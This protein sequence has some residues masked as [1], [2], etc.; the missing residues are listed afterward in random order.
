MW[1]EKVSRS[2]DNLI[3]LVWSHRM[4]C[5]MSGCEGQRQLCWSQLDR[6]IIKHSFCNIADVDCFLLC[7]SNLQVTELYICLSCCDVFNHKNVSHYQSASDRIFQTLPWKYIFLS[8]RLSFYLN[9][10]LPLCHVLQKNMCSRP[11]TRF[12]H[13]EVH[14]FTDIW[15]VV[16]AWLPVLYPGTDLCVGEQLIAFKGRCS[17]WEIIPF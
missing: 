1:L 12:R 14:A 2:V 13:P 3:W 9:F 4:C 15:T 6:S 11:R 5:T 7:F 17:F 16:V 8:Y 10:S